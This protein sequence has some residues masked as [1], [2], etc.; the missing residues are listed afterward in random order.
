MSNARTRHSP[1]VLWRIV[2][3]GLPRPTVRLR[4]TA[5]YGGLF[6]ASGGVLLAITYLLV[7][8]FPGEFV[9][10]RPAG[11]PLGNPHDPFVIAAQLSA[12]QLH[13]LLVRSCI[14][15]A[16]MAVISL[17]LGWL[18]AGRVLRPLRVITAATKMISE[19]NLRDRL[20]LRGPDDE[21]KDLADTID[22]LLTRLDA[23]FD[24]QRAFVANASH[25][26]RTPLTLSQALLQMRLRDPRT[27]AEEF[28]STCEELLAAGQHQ[29]R[30]IEALLVLARS[31]RGLDH[32]QPIDLA[33]IAIHTAEEHQ[34][35]A[36]T[37]GI[38]LEVRADPAS[39]YGDASLIERLVTNLV[40]NAVRYNTTGGHIQLLIDSQNAHTNLQVTNTG[41]VIPEDQVARL[42]QPF[43]R[44]SPSRVGDPDGLGL[45][46]SIVTAIAHAHH[47][48]LAARAQPHGG[49]DICI[50]FP[51]YPAPAPT[52]PVATAPSDRRSEPALALRR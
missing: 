22:G 17:G 24:A 26:L 48:T 35:R 6:L 32:Q 16:I 42:L 39:I 9:G 11:A 46:L 45:G 3:A 25:E 41:P 36:N 18:V 51:T 2:R 1:L 44:S 52:V 33:A 20:A 40:E 31:Q 37:H 5:L 28:R 13:V 21:I 47:A 15:L 27:T 49:L 50:R 14:A 29:E 4:L 10:H 43:Q 7:A 30:L 23:A 38:R 34:P 19:D 12:A 8:G